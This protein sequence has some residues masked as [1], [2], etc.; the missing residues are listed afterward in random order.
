MWW[1]GSKPEDIY[2]GTRAFAVCRG[3]ERLVAQATGSFDEGLSHLADWCQRD[4]TRRKRRRVWLS[5]SLCRPFLAPPVDG[6][7]DVQERHKAFEAMAPDLTG[8]AAPCTVW[9][10]RSLGVAVASDV[11]SRLHEALKQFRR[12]VAS[13]APWWSA[14]LTAALRHD[15]SP[16]LLTVRDCDSLTVLAGL[17]KEFSTATSVAPLQDDAAASAALMRLLLTRDVEPS[18]RHDARLALNKTEG[19]DAAPLGP[20]VEWS[21]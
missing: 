1:A 3:S 7:R 6:L 15:K 19:S 13:I 8:L 21:R 12:P 5:G 20:L 2:L 11:L 4:S 18:L 9:I 14:L 17:D 16:S 10:D